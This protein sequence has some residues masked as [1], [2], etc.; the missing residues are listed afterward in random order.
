MKRIVHSILSPP[1]K[2]SLHNFN[3]NLEVQEFYGDCK[4]TVQITV[5]HIHLIERLRITNDLLVNVSGTVYP[6]YPATGESTH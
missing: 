4:S 1:R 6:A 2:N 5:T 3:R